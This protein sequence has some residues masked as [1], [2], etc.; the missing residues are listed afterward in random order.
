[1]T[2]ANQKKPWARGV[3]AVVVLV[4]G[5]IALTGSPQ[6]ARGAG[7]LPEGCWVTISPTSG[8]VGTLVSVTGS[9]TT[10]N[11]QG[12]GGAFGFADE[13]AGVVV[14]YLP[15]KD[16]GPFSFRFRVPAAMPRGNW[17]AAAQTYAGG[18]PVAPGPTTFV[19]PMVAPFSATFDVTSAPSGYADYVAV[20]SAPPDCGGCLGA[21]AYDLFRAGG[22]VDTSYSA[23]DAPGSAGDVHQ[24][25]PIIAAAFS[26]DGAGYWMAGADGGV[27]TYGNARFFGSAADQH[28]AYPVVGIA[29][30]P[31][32]RGYWLI[33]RDGGVFAFGDAGYHGR[34]WFTGA[35]C[36]PPP[37]PGSATDC[38]IPFGDQVSTSAA[39]GIEAT[40]DGAGYWIVT[41]DGSVY[42]FGDAPFY[43]S[44]GGRHLDA[45]ITGM[46][47]T[48]DRHGY[49]LVGADGG[50]F[51][52][53]DARY[54][55]SAVGVG[56]WPV[57]GIASTAEGHG[58][59]LLASDGG[60][61]TYGDAHFAGSGRS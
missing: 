30:T 8:P 36:A 52:F 1:M 31:D 56:S 6:P 43:G 34:V 20:I 4:G 59:W 33:G 60:V 29:A 46:G 40:S 58:Y 28:L 41:A 42:T 57:V 54:A 22:F 5:L 32:G 38:V 17:W 15:A 45:P 37:P 12:Y 55:G 21:D 2:G 14:G 13:D 51:S 61:F 49:W 18:G 25:A 53:G 39:V 47:L 16:G 24:A 26:P 11:N 50:V 9:D 35:P 10:C 7:A 48:P 23:P 44:M 19:A 27:F 3:L